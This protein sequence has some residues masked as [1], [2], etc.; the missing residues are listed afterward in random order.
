[1]FLFLNIIALGG[2]PFFTGWII[3]RFAQFDFTHPGPHGLLSAV[4]GLFGPGAA[5]GVSFTAQ[6]PGGVAPKG[7]MVTQ[8]MQCMRTEAGATR[9]G[10]LVTIG[11]YAWGAI[12]YLLASYGMA[13]RLAKAD[14]ARAAG[15]L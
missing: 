5:H 7:A 6:C 1:M 12:H 9:Q 13:A 15:Q 4:A 3:D 8:V 11:F 14:A 10:I 2:G